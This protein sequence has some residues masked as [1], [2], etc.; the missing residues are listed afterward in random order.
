MTTFLS[1]MTKRPS[2]PG[3][4]W[5]DTYRVANHGGIIRAALTIGALTLICQ[6]VAMAKELW[7]AAW[8]GTSDALDA[9][10]MA[11]VIPTFVINVVA[12]SFQSALIP[13]YIRV[14]EQ[15]DPE[16]ARRLFS[17]VMGYGFILLLLMG[18]LVASGSSLLLPILASGYTPEKIA[19]TQTL[20]Y[21][22]LPVIVLQGTVVI[23][24]AVLNA[25]HR[26]ALAAIAPVLSPAA[27]IVA[28]VT[29][30]S[31]WMVFSLMVGTLA[32]V[33]GQVIMLGWGLKKQALSLRLHW[34]RG[35]RRVRAVMGQYSHVV[36]GAVFMSATTLIDQAMSAM[37]A[38]GS[39]AVLNYGSR[40]VT[41]GLGLAATS[42]ATAAFPY[43]SKQAVE[44]EGMLLWKTL[45]F[46]IRWIF[47]IAVP[48][49]ILTFAFSESIVRLLFERGAFLPKDTQQV[50]HVQALLVWQAPFY[51]GGVLLARV[52]SSLQA[53]HVLMWI[54]GLSLLVKVTLNY[55]LMGWIG[56]AGIALS[57]SLVFLGSFILLYLYTR[58]GLI[59]L[60][61]GTTKPTN[62]DEISSCMLSAN[63]QRHG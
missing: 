7:V 9:F 42:I 35:D 34:D 46:Y 47:I 57:T 50:S 31:H 44:K 20:L 59:R 10:L 29:V 41:V 28:L 39:V 26:F 14:R 49:S 27:I 13:A 53:N 56:V 51:I 58:V 55:F 4:R 32:G 23:W 52:V 63:G 22:L 19:L 17:N 2:E 3:P 1:I 18:V 30:G 8:F 36:V 40:V 33:T 62:Q 11:I 43:F 12:G 38:P 24:S 60:S 25:H 21:W 45:C 16:A 48:L 37:L 54:A 5:T 6:L 15:E 61:G